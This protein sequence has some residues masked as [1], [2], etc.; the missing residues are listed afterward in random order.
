MDPKYSMTEFDLRA[1]L[2]KTIRK[3]LARNTYEIV[4]IGTKEVAFTRPTLKEIVSLANELGD[5][6]T[7]QCNALCLAQALRRPAEKN[8]VIR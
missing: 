2:N 8:K 1:R 5:R 6:I 4:D 3:N 7:L